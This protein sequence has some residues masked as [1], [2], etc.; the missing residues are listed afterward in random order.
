MTIKQTTQELI[1]ECRGAEMRNCNWK[2]RIYDKEIADKIGITP[3]ALS[4]I[5]TGVT[6]PD[7]ATFI[8]LIKYAYKML[9]KNRTLEILENVF[10]TDSNTQSE[11]ES[12]TG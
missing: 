3:T 2:R 5:S 9:G 4:R 12:K 10:N 7:I 1:R 6:A 11:Q 8:K